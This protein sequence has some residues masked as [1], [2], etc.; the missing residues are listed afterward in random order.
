MHFYL[1]LKGPPEGHSGVWRM[2][3]RWWL[4]SSWWDK[5][6]KNSTVQST[7]KLQVQI[8][9]REATPDLSCLKNREEVVSEEET[10]GGEHCHKYA[11]SL[12]IQLPTK[13][14]SADPNPN[15]ISTNCDCVLGRL[16][17][18]VAIPGH[19]LNLFERHTISWREGYQI[20]WIFW[21]S[22][23]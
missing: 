12:L 6:L 23:K 8:Q 3:S 15:H 19:N 5:S 13:S 21:E 7:A 16:L 18:V 11:N 2:Q 22:L 17:K 14:Q 10:P 1:F 4:S 20:G 9:N